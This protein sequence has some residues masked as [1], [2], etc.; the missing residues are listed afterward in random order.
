MINRGA[1]NIVLVSRGTSP[2]G[3]VKELIN[4]ASE[5]GVTIVVRRCDVVDPADVE[6]LIAHGLE[7]M[8]PI[9]G[10]IHGAMVLRVSS[11]HAFF[12]DK[13]DA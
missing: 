5:L 8:P 4:E 10:V 13:F 6:E 3:K 11:D 9:K 2:S 1:R 12:R 7:D